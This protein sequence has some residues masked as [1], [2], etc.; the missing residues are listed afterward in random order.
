MGKTLQT[1]AGSGMAQHPTRCAR[2]TRRASTEALLANMVSTTLSFTLC[3][4]ISLYCQ[5]ANSTLFIKFCRLLMLTCCIHC[6]AV[7]SNV[8]VSDYH[9]ALFVCSNS[10]GSWCVLCVVRVIL[11][12]PYVL[13]S[14]HARQQTHVL[15]QST[16]GPLH[17]GPA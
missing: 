16:D 3:C 17:A 6:T 8:H 9:S 10:S 13:S 7:P 1:N 12:T 11:S 4:D 5:V 14:R 15:L 2:S